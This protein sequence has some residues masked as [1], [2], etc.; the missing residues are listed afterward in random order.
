MGKG[1]PKF[2]RAAIPVSGSGV[3]YNY[4]HYDGKSVRLLCQPKRGGYKTGYKPLPTAQLVTTLEELSTQYGLVVAV[5]VR[6]AL[7]NAGYEEVV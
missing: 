7:L 3:A 2:R 5:K 4:I 6:T 1:P